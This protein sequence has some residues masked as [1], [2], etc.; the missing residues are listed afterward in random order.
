MDSAQQCSFE[1]INWSS[2]NADF[3]ARY[4]RFDHIE[5]IET[6]PAIELKI[7]TPGSTSR[8][9]ILL[10]TAV[11]SSPRNLACWTL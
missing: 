7:T 3:R 10:E 2:V 4:I 6:L 9:G 1:D 11:G 8:S 5:G